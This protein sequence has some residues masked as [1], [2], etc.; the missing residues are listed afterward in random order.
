MKIDNKQI[1]RLVKD[2][3]AKTSSYEWRRLRQDAYHQLEFIVTMHFLEKHL[4]KKG[5]VL[6]AGG[7]PGR[8]TIEL[9]KRGLGLEPMGIMQDEILRLYKEKRGTSVTCPKCERKA[10]AP[11]SHDLK[12][13]TF[14]MCLDCGFS[15]RGTDENAVEIL[16]K[17]LK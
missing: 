16:T 6:D 13:K 4:P 2:W 7:G 12:G 17:L 15:D 3:F 5:L 10:F 8:Y 11:F 14:H 9:A 1:D